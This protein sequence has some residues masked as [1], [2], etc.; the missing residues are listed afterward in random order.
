MSEGQRWSVSW[1]DNGCYIG[2]L[3]N[4]GGMV[5]LERLSV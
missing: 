1:R 4:G 5:M 2:H 3:F